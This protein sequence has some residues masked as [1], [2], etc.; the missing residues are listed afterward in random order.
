[1]RVWLVTVILLFLVVQLYQW[2]RGF[3]LPLPIYVMAGAFL[4]IASNYEK[5]MTSFLP[6]VTSQ[7]DNDIIHQTASLVEEQNVLEESKGKPNS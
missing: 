4:A 1:M 5:G 3:I 2:L 7:P 6:T